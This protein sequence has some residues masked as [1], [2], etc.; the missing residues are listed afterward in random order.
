[1]NRSFSSSL[2]LVFA[3]GLLVNVYL[4]P[5]VS[6]QDRGKQKGRFG[7][8]TGDVSDLLQKAQ[9]G[10]AQAQ[11]KLAQALN[12]GSLSR[13]DPVAAA[14]WACEAASQGSL[15]AQ[16]LLG[17]LYGH[18]VV[19]YDT[20]VKSAVLKGVFGSGPGFTVIS[21]PSVEAN[22]VNGVPINP[23]N[24]FTWV[25]IAMQHLPKWDPTSLDK[26]QRRIW[27]DEGAAYVVGE[28]LAG[29]PV[30]VARRLHLS[31]EIALV[32]DDLAKRIDYQT[33]ARIGETT[34]EWQPNHERPW[35]ASVNCQST[36]SDSD[37]SA[38]IA[39]IRG[40]RYSALPPAVAGPPKAVASS[41]T[42]LTV[43]NNSGYQIVIYL[44]GPTDRALT[45]E[46]NSSRT[47]EVSAGQY[48]IAVETPSASFTPFYGE[49]NLSTGSSYRET[50]SAR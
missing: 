10:D 14:K 18:I 42:A 6:A 37:T 32:R 19:K 1:M 33:A 16:L 25:T 9:S 28:D 41:G 7:S 35:K 38:A 23:Q 30:S 34:R 24:A 44:S 12:A 40:G 46:T 4:L 43:E 26:K 8:S 50:F 31:R 48:R 22:D 45:L 21:T 3:A 20:E 13:S 49:Q 47:L 39:R 29:S 15:E 2:P 5:Q 17:L 27:K 36:P 11:T